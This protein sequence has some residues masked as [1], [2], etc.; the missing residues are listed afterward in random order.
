MLAVGDIDKANRFGSYSV[1]TGCAGGGGIEWAVVGGEQVECGSVECCGVA[2]FDPEGAL[3]P[4]DEPGRGGADGGDRFE[5]ALRCGG[6]EHRPALVGGEGWG[7]VFAAA[8][9]VPEPSVVG[10]VLVEEVW[11]H[12]AASEAKAFDESLEIGG[13]RSEGGVV[14][15]AEFVFEFL[16]E[17]F[18]D[19]VSV[20]DGRFGGG[21]ADEFDGAA[22]PAT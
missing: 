7:A 20:V 22:D 13:E 15:A 17:Q 3:G 14:D 5:V 16:G 12:H 21:C 18:D 19:V 1:D 11:V 9:D 8:P 6:E 10:Q 4:V 2:S